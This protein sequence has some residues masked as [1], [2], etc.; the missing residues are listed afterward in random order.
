MPHWSS[1]VRAHPQRSSSNSSIMSDRNS[2]EGGPSVDQVPPE[3]PKRPSPASSSDFPDGGRHA[4][5]TVLG[6]WFCLFS[7]YGFISSA[8]V[9]QDYYET[10]LL[11]Q[12]SPS[13]I[14]WIPA[15]QLFTLSA[16]SPFVGAFFDSYGPRIPVA[17][18]SFLVILGLMTQSLSTQ[19]YQLIL[20]QAICAGLGMGM[21]FHS[22][23]NA[24]ATWFKRRRGLA[25]GLAS[26][27]SG[28]GGVIL[29]IMFD[30]LVGQIGFPWTVRTI[31]FVLLPLQLVAIFTVQ[32]RLE[33]QPKRFHIMEL[34]H[35]FRDLTF[36]LNAAACFFGTLGLL[37]PFNYMKVAAASA[38]VSPN[39]LPYILPILNSTSIIGRIVPLWA[40]DHLGVFNMATI[41]VFLGAILVLALW[42]P[43]AGSSGA[44]IA[45]TVLY[46]LPL[47][48]FV[49]T[50]A[51]L[52]AKIS[53]IREIGVRVGATF[54]VNAV[55]GLVGSPLA[56]LL[57][58]V[59][60]WSSGP[61]E[62]RG[63]QIFCG[64]AIL[65]SALLF[66]LTRVYTGGWSVTKRV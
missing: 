30:R 37:L 59:G 66:G 64:L 57:I 54:F 62:F 33:H 50:I 63:L 49:A 35:P 45:F 32:S 5:L 18:G 13:T 36:D 58:G 44:V 51:A 46:G 48:Y 9:Y 40:G 47:G 27:G 4:W 17:V 6:A 20:S 7:S 19:Y 10:Q 8:G 2:S 22:S 26:S 31:G 28:V 55:A 25:M 14:S 39:L 38:G 12:Y 1:L 15:L 34:L 43:G 24:V 16:L 11:S 56:G 42:V 65:V 3:K 61:E 53:D 52:V 21:I 23:I 60:N 41:F 29:P